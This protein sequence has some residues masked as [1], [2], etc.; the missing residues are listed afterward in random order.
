MVPECSS[1]SLY[2]QRCSIQGNCH[3]AQGAPA[4]HVAELEGLHHA[5]Q[6]HPLHCK[7]LRPHVDALLQAQSP[8][9][10]PPLRF[11][12]APARPAHRLQKQTW[13]QHEL[14]H[15]KGPWASAEVAHSMHTHRSLSPRLIQLCLRQQIH[16]WVSWAWNPALDKWALWGSVRTVEG[17]PALLEASSV[18]GLVAVWVSPVARAMAVAAKV[19]WAH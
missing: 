14:V 16:S 9:I 2:P 12:P 6:G 4:P 18:E 3:R 7:S 19:E 10:P 15:W 11:P 8:T 17:V 1:P 13:Q 5:I